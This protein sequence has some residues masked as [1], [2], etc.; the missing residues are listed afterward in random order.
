VKIF[1]FIAEATGT[2]YTPTKSRAPFRVTL[3]SLT[4]AVGVCIGIMHA[5]SAP[6]PPGYGVC[7]F[8]WCPTDLVKLGTPGWVVANEDA[9]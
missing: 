8:A 7:M 5:A 6:V 1:G 3:A 9:P 4:L 2:A